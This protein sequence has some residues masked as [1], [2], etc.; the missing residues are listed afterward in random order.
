MLMGTGFK[1]TTSQLLARV[2][3]AMAVLWLI[4]LTGSA[5]YRSAPVTNQAT[6]HAASREQRTRGGSATVYPAVDTDP[7]PQSLF[8]IWTTDNGLPQ[9]SVSSIL[10]TKDGYLWLTTNDGLVRYDGVHF[11]IFNAGNTNGLGTSRLS[12]LLEDRDGNLWVIAEDNS[13]IRYSKGIF[14]TL[15]IREGY[16]EDHTLRVR[17]DEQGVL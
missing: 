3:T 12:R 2:L 9:N 11:T 6:N 7:A 10:Q 4:G 1:V 16:P 13:L 17:C 8:D 5:R 15:T 14:T